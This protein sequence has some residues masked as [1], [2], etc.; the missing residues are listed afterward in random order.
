MG[1]LLWV[2]QMKTDHVLIWL[3]FDYI[4]LIFRRVVVQMRTRKTRS[5]M[6]TRLLHVVKHPLPR[7][8]NFRS[9]WGQRV[10]V[11]RARKW[12]DWVVDC[13]GNDFICTNNSSCHPDWEPVYHV[14][15]SPIRSPVDSLI[16]PGR[17]GCNLNSL[18]P[19]QFEQ[20]L[21][22]DGWGISCEIALTWMS[23]DFTDD[24]STLVQV[25][26]WCRQAT[27]HYLSQCWPRS[28]SP[29]DV[30]RPQWVN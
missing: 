18:A 10:K 16:G 19:G 8:A 9:C 24:Q 29:Y 13:C 4:S 7:R 27:S 23:L 5:Q 28:L 21:V 1:C 2:L 11:K 26:A 3:Y 20:I 30:T 12:S 15:I 22:I 25:M 14:K 17:C 6:P